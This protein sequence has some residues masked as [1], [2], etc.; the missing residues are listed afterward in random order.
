M[1]GCRV[2]AQHINALRSMQRDFCLEPLR[3]CRSA[4]L[5]NSNVCNAE[6]VLELRGQWCVGQWCVGLCW[7]WM[8]IGLGVRGVRGGGGGCFMSSRCV[9]HCQGMGRIAPPGTHLCR[10]LPL[11]CRTPPYRPGPN[12]CGPGAGNP[13]T[14]TSGAP[15]P[16]QRHP[17]PPPPSL[18][19][20]CIPSAAPRE[21]PV[22]SRVV[23]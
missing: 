16:L 8:G 15:C 22:W 5:R 13:A 23:C 14:N 2:H 6:L 11:F 17:P 1:N 21:P 12:S 7:V 18:Q 9:A 4:M 19:D 20:L 10:P 3:R